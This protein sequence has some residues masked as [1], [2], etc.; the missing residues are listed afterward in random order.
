MSLMDA[1]RLIGEGNHPLPQ[2]GQV[3]EQERPDYDQVEP[4]FACPNCGEDC[5]DEL[6]NVDDHVHCA[7]CGHDYDL[8][9]ERR[10][11]DNA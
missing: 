4:G 9:P 8:E 5:D 6:V 1:L 3:Q 7:T 11:G 2:A 10:G